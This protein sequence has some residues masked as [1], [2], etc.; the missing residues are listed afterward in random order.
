MTSRIPAAVARRLADLFERHCAAAYLG[1]PVTL[2]QHMLQ[3]ATLAEQEDQPEAVVVAALLHDIGHVTGEKGAFTMDDGEDRR[4]EVAGA[5]FLER[6]L[7]PLVVNCV[8]HHVAA[9]R[10]L[11]ATRPGY[12][13]RL[14]AASL[15]SLALQG[16]P[17]EAGEAARFAA[18]PDLDAI[19]AVRLFDDAG[20]QSEL[21]TPG[22]GH[23]SAMVER[24][25]HLRL[26]ADG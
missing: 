26:A 10:Y 15:H 5:R 18:H 1:E 17:M 2:A 24:M 9:K 4:H 12:R 20:K 3:A 14:S 21:E 25:V 22:F 11:A 13:E 16:G 7:P 23:F 8:R 6:F 19:I